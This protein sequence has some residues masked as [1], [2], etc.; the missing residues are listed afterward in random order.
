MRSLSN[1]LE[2]AYFHRFSFLSWFPGQKSNAFIDSIDS[3]WQD[4]CKSRFSLMQI[5]LTWLDILQA[6]FDTFLAWIL[7][8]NLCCVGLSQISSIGK[9]TADGQ[10]GNKWPPTRV[11]TGM[12]RFRT[13]C[14]LTSF[15]AIICRIAQ[16]ARPTMKDPRCAL[17]PISQLHTKV[18]QVMYGHSTAPVHFIYLQTL[19]CAMEIELFYTRNWGSFVIFRDHA[20]LGLWCYQRYVCY[21]FRSRTVPHPSNNYVC[22]AGLCMCH[23]YIIRQILSVHYPSYLCFMH[24]LISSNADS[25]FTLWV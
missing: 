11:K 1:P 6:S 9:V 3:S 23:T 25:S 21:G 7:R 2:I 4:N 16:I 15:Q 19:F 8:S 12:Q 14:N 18:G 20:I 17:C 10:S 22:E 13:L 5:Q 24:A